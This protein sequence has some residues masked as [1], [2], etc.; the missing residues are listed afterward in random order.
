MDNKEN[1]RNYIWGYFQLH[2]GQRLTTF[3][4]Y[5]VISTLFTSGYFIAL[6]DIPILSLVLSFILIALSFI[7]WKLDSRN[8]QL[9]KNAENGLK[10]IEKEDN[11][12][13]K[14]NDIHILNIFS[15]EEK[16]TEILKEKK[17]FWFWK[18]L[19]TYS[20]CFNSVFWIFAILG[21]LGIVCSIITIWYPYFFTN[22]LANG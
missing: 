12:E 11:V 16:Q 7:F 10:E 18:R 21:F 19:Y 14:I 15:Y 4:F 6:K 5:I 17:T 22:W 3:N 2:A 1:L 20:T 8:K 13:S 9:I